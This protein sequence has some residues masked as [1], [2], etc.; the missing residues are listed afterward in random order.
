M[1]Y[2]L[3]VDM[4]HVAAFLK[5]FSIQLCFSSSPKQIADD[6]DGND[7]D[8]GGSDACDII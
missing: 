8:F 6:G 3:T 5:H 7:G 2:V 4:S 1:K